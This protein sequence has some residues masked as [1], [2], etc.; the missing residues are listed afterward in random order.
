MTT[1]MGM[2]VWAVA[3]IGLFATAC[4]PK[5]PGDDVG[6]ETGADTETSTMPSSQS[7]S[8][9]ESDAMTE[10]GDPASGWFE[11]GWGIDS[12]APIEAGDEFPIVYG[13]QGSAMFPMPIRAGEFVLPDDPSDY[14]DPR[15]PKMNLE[16]DIE[17]HNDGFGGHFKRIANYPLVFEILPDGTYEFLYVAIIL[18]DEKV[19]EDLVGLPAHLRVE[20]QPYESEPIVRELDLVVA[21]APVD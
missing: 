21:L 17:G 6:E 10:T 19:P 18:P 13:N 11:V 14:L 16:L 12:F 7:Q 20:I 9:S 3:A 15:A 5:D 2:G 8:A 1:R 4:E